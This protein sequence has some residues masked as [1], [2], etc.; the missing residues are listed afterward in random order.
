MTA[1]FTKFTGGMIG[2]VP[3]NIIGKNLNMPH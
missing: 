3:Y 1:S 2:N